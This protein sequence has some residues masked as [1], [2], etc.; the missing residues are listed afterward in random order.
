MMIF[1]PL[2][3]HSDDQTDSILLCFI[4]L[5]IF[6]YFSLDWMQS[7]QLYINLISYSSIY[8]LSALSLQN[9]VVVFIC[10]VFIRTFFTPRYSLLQP[11]DGISY[12]I[13]MEIASYLIDKA[14]SVTV[15]GSSELPYQN[16]LGREIGRATMLV[17][18]ERDGERAESSFTS[19]FSRVV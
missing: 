9:V 6:N 18:H 5:Q 10:W 7:T 16:T 2:Y 15:I 11:L 4:P 8:L 14:S 12:V 1:F 17:R 3:F 13:G 19:L